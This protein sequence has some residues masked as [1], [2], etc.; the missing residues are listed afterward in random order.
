MKPVIFVAICLVLATSGCV[1]PPPPNPLIVK[2]AQPVGPV[3][4]RTFWKDEG[5]TGEAS[6]V[7]DLGQQRVFFYK[8]DKVVGGSNISTGKAGFE[9]PTGE[10]KVIQ[11]DK[12]HASNL[13]GQYVDESGGVVRSDVDVTKDRPPAGATFRGA[14]M[15]YFL[16]FYGGYGLHAGRVPAHRASHGCVRLPRE[17]A[18]HFF[19]NAVIGTPVSLVK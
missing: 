15:P 8:G 16:R 5:I 12:D 3:K 14:K 18:M 10:Y 11:K 2:R 7:I 13:Y 19:N 4:K 17:M 1:T 6:I 9:T